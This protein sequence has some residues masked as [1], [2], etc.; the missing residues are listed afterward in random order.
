MCAGGPEG[1][2]FWAKCE[3]TEASEVTRA[4]TEKLEVSQGTW[5]SMEYKVKNGSK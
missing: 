4:V 3:H 1:G 2:E 5:F